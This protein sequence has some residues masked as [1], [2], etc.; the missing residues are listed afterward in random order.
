MKNLVVYFIAATLILVSGCNQSP[1]DE[2]LTKPVD[3]L[4]KPT[5][6]MEQ[7]SY[8]IGNTMGENLR[9]DSIYDL[10]YE[11][12]IMAIR[13]QL[14]G[15]QPLLERYE[16]DSIMQVMSVIL[17]KRE[18]G[19]NA[20][21]E[22]EKE[23]NR[24]IAFEFLT[25]NKK[26]PGIQTT[27]TGLQYKIV[28]AGSGSTPRP[29]DHVKIHVKTLLMD[30]KVIADTKEKGK[31]LPIHLNDNL[32]RCWYESILKMNIG[33]KWIIYSPP[34]LAFG[35]LGN[36]RIPGNMVMIYEI[37]LIDFQLE[38]F[39]DEEMIPSRF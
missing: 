8:I 35:E 10:N 1:K 13:T 12:F 37:E 38:A 3:N 14:E 17:Q 23:K 6:L 24:K 29:N 5:E 2:I 16:M 4:K 26:K 36:D 27:A 28:K 19:R 32:L 34:E 7:F 31:P 30:G 20:K 21:K 22:M 39:P 15:K 18:E 25:N 9:K 11:Y 33:S